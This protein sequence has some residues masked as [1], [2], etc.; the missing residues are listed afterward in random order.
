M[1]NRGE[2]GKGVMIVGVLL[3]LSIVV[4]GLTGVWEKGL[5]G[6][7]FDGVERYMLSEKYQDNKFGYR[8]LYKDGEDLLRIEV[9][10]NYTIEETELAVR[11]EVLMI[12]GL[13]ENARSPYPDDISNEIVCAAEYKPVSASKNVNGLNLEY[14]SGFINNRLV[15]GSCTQEQITY[16]DTMM[17]FY[18]DK[19]KKYYQIEI[20]RPVAEYKDNINADE[21]ILN[22]IVCK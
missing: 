5:R 6:I 22:S 13:F 4:L 7:F 12:K 10:P 19:Q 2:T 3:V 18:C 11:S 8:A 14:F 1:F 15:F 21:E 16:H 20:I 9:R 17:M